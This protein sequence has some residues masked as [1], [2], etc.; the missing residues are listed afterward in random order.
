M[1][2]SLMYLTASRPNI[3]FSTCLCFDLKGYSDSDYASCNMHRKSTSGACQLLRGKLVCR[4]AK[5]QQSV[6]M[7]SARA[8]YVAAAGC[9]ANI[10]WMKSQLT[11]YDIIYEKRNNGDIGI[12]T[13]RNA[14]RAH[15]LLHSSEYVSPPSLEVVRPW[16]QMIGYN[17]E[18]GAKGTLK[19]SCLP[20]RWRLMMAQ[21]IHYLG[22]KTGGLDQISNK[23][24]T[25]LYCLAN[26]VQVDFAKIIWEDIIHKLNKKT[27]E[28]VVSL[29]SFF[30]FHS[31]SALE[32]DASA[33]S[34]AGGTNLSVLVYMT[35]SA[36]DGLKTAHTELATLPKTELKDSFEITDLSRE[37]QE[38]K[39]TELKNIQWELPAGFL[40]LPR[41]VS[42]V[43]EKLKTL[44]ALPSILNKVI[45]TLNKFS[46]V[47]KNAS[48]ATGAL[49]AE[50][51]KNTYPAT[52]EANLKNDLVDLMGIDVVE[53]YHKK[54]LLN[55]GVLGED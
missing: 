9:C 31:E 3:Q 38:L 10:L 47:V 21:I 28:N 12:T 44:D 27:K 18:I 37:V 41:Q 25:I 42:S 40:D 55:Y 52:K 30:H 35:K 24:A 43:Q 6:A 8:E 48:G 49:P 4:S 23:D 32:C 39:V 19:K 46:P 26:G 2:G 36:G 45:D 16:F 13:L 50:G 33:D 11:D 51:E 5:K 15:Y 29:H 34:Q 20:P 53:E 7:S 22:G 17:G 54:K 1:I 14:L